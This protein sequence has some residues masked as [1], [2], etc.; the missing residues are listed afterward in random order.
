VEHLDAIPPGGLDLDVAGADQ[1]VAE[2]PE[3]T[4]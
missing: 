2:R 1:A 3:G 4:A